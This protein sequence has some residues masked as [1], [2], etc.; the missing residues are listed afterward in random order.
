MFLAQW[1]YNWCHS[2]I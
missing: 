2:R 1:L